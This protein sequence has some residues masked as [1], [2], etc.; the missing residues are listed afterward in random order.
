[1]AMISLLCIS[2]GAS[3]SMRWNVFVI[4]PVIGAALAIVVVVGVARGD[5]AGWLAVEM[6]VIIVCLELGYAARLVVYL[7]ADA[8]RALTAMVIRP[9]KAIQNRMDS[10]IPHSGPGRRYRA[11]SRGRFPTPWSAGTSRESTGVGIRLPK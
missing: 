10:A 8:I 9:L 1:M 5:G 2:I 7:L 11:M 3:L 6:A 4:F